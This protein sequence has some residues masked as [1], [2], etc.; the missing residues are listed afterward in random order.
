M[1]L[2]GGSGGVWLET[3]A[4]G[5]AVVHRPVG[6]WTPAVHALLGHLADRGLGGVPRVVATTA[7][8]ETLTFL[9][10]R[11]LD[12]GVD[13]AADDV[14]A[15]A[16]AWLRRFHDIVRGWD[17]G[18]QTWRQ[19]DAALTAGQVICHNDPGTYN[20]VT[21]ADGFAGL[22]DWDQ[23]GP[24]DPLHDVAFLCWT[25]VPLVV[26]Q[27][28]AEVARRLRIVAESYGQIAPAAILEAAAARMELSVQRIAAGI[29]RGDPGMLALRA[30]GEPDRTRGAV[31][32]FLARRD[33]I[34]S[35]LEAAPA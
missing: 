33:A 13:T 2:P 22:I 19:T 23:A 18:P 14:L 29:E 24:G 27:P 35:A 17:P 8:T 34:R 11:T 5:G 32:E 7:S 10:G 26:P 15:Q 20:W 6:P 28:P 16:A 12:P 3:D 4:A 30:H 25:G 21:D 1:H 9:P 31:Q